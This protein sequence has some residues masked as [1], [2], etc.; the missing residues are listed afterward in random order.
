MQSLTNIKDL[1]EQS[2]PRSPPNPRQLV[3]CCGESDCAF[4][5]QTRTSVDGLEAD[6]KTAAK[7]GQVRR[8][9]TLFGQRARAR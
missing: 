4:L 9:V 3:C 2:I 6:V 5:L 8:N 1:L 7:L